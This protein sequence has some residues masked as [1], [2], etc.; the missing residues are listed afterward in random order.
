M[1]YTFRCE[2]E[3]GESTTKTFNHDSIYEIIPEFVYFLRGVSFEDDLIKN[4]LEYIIDTQY[5][6]NE[7]K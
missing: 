3:D 2:H 5:P 1:Y 6:E 4:A 7:D